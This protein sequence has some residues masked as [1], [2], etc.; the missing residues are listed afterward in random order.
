MAIS[1]IEETGRKT[2]FSVE[3]NG[4]VSFKATRRFIVTS[5]TRLT[6]FESVSGL[7]APLEPYPGVPRA[8]VRDVD[9]DEIE[10]YQGGYK[11]I[12]TVSY[13]TKHFSIAQQH[14]ELE[15]N[16]LEKPISYKWAPHLIT[17]SPCKD[18]DGKFYKDSAKNW[19]RNPPLHTIN[20]AALTVTKN[21]RS[22]SGS[23]ALSLI[24]KCNSGTFLGR[25]RG[26]LQI[27]DVAPEEVSN[28]EMNYVAVS[29]TILYNPLGWDIVYTP[30]MGP[31][32]IDHET[33]KLVYPT[34]GNGYAST[35]MVLLNGQGYK[36]EDGDEPV[37]LD[38]RVADYID[39][40]RVFAA[41]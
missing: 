31:Q 28:D 35:E 22:F 7:P 26:A 11:W 9:A 15:D 32:Y 21:F 24:G 18:L 19:L 38:F 29:T 14:N 23:Y 17:V 20:G 39:F 3:E 36:L 25:K 37:L 2:G 1:C 34:D 8:R 30:D 41:Y 5:D 33:S 4:T 40:N 27:S 12:V 10:E 6:G 13:N 16:P